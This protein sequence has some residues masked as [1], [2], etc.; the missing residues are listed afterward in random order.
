MP[1]IF[2]CCGTK[3]DKK[4]KEEAANDSNKVLKI[5]P[6]PEFENFT[7]KFNRANGQQLGLSLDAF[8]D[9]K[10]ILVTVVKDAGLIPQLSSTQENGQ[11]PIKVNDVIVQVNDVVG[12]YEGMM[13]QLKE[14]TDITLHI[15][16][17]SAGIKPEPAEEPPIVEKNALDSVAMTQKVGEAVRVATEADIKAWFELLDVESREKLKGAFVKLNEENLNDTTTTAQ[18]E[19]EKKLNDTT[20]PPQAG[21]LNAT[22]KPVNGTQIDNDG[23]RSVQPES[24]EQDEKVETNPCG[25]F[26]Y[27]LQIR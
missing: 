23:T 27:A 14:A 9:K 25:W 19:N 18:A 10:S 17:S 11:V 6:E 20:T 3:N 7:V 13:Q 26:C 16:R 24:G 21:G 5:D 15:K 22:T 4:G 1:R 2:P 8:D 12:S